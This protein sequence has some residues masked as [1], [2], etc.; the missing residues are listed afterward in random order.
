MQQQ[1]VQ[2]DHA[3]HECGIYLAEP[4][5]E[6]SYL[7]ACSVPSERELEK[8]LERAQSRGV[9]CVAFRE[10]DIGNQ[11]TAFCSE[12]ISGNTRKVFSKYPTWRVETCLR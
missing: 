9:K 3:A 1:L 8:A 10:P 7:V 11:L 2:D 5:D 12:P 6:V 4:A